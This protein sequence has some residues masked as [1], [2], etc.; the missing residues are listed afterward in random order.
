MNGVF[1]DGKFYVIQNED[2]SSSKFTWQGGCTGV[3]LDDY[4]TMDRYI[5][6]FQVE[7]TEA[8]TV[9][10]ID[11]GSETRSRDTEEKIEV[12][13]I[14][15]EYTLFTVSAR[16]PHGPSYYH[17]T[18]DDCDE[19]RSIKVPRGKRL[20]VK[21]VLKVNLQTGEYELPEGYTVREI[22][23]EQSR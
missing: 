17:E 14:T 7:D 6:D 1:E 3:Y 5:E 8:E 2:S 23:S 15:K 13:K 18:Y 22:Q 20:L 12:E 16:I 19:V 4:W 21:G 11:M 10:Y 9:T